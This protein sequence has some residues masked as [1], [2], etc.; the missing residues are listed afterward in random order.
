MNQRM[1]DRC[2]CKG[3]DARHQSCHS[4]CESY[5]DWKNENDKVN[6]QLYNY[7]QNQYALDQVEDHRYGRSR[8]RKKK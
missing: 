1:S 7:Y 2:P 3:C 5:M 8:R 4:E 6:M